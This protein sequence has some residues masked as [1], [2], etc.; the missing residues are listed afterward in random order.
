VL[1]AATGLAKPQSDRE[2][3]EETIERVL[4]G[5]R[6][7]IAIKGQPPVR[8]TLAEEM[9]QS[10]VP[11]ISIAVIDDGQIAWARGFGVKQAGTADPV[12]TSTL[13]EAQSI[14]KAVTAT[15]TLV[16]VNSGRLSLEES[17]NVYLKSW[18]LPYNEYQAQEKV[19]LRRILSH[20]SGLNVGSFAGYRAGEP[21]PSLLQI[22]DGEKPANN[23]PIRVDFTPGSKSRY[24]GGGAQV[25]EEL[26]M[27]VTSQP[28]PELMK[29]LVLVPAAMTLST[30]EEPLPEARWAEAASGH[31]GEGAVVKGKW[32]IQPQMAAGGLWT[33]PTDLA[34][35]ALQITRAWKG[36]R[37]RLFSKRIATEMLT[38]QKAPYGL[39]VEVQGTGSRLEFSHGGSNL[40]FRALMVMFPAVG[41]G[42]VMMA[43]GDRADWVI[44]SLIRSIASEYHW[45]ALMQTE[46]AVVPLGTAQLDALVG[47]YAL[48]PG[49]S[50][51][52]VTYEITR[53]GN[54]LFAELKGLGSYPKYELFPSNATSFFSL[55]GL[56]VNFTLDSS[57]RAS[58]LKMGEIMGIRK[59]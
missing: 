11:G 58:S 59:P 34:N 7:P 30:Y 1:L 48:P 41:K 10:H 51:E 46:R 19:T 5:M 17:P 29:R 35:W 33:T 36:G 57:G 56:D 39:G 3:S 31:D 21:L 4:S 52:P 6:P 13:F 25:M 40:G 26:L 42:A 50:G 27:D 47:V 22:L 55:V 38:V 37:N 23:P 53:N 54:K 15:A 12:T 14:S 49:P 28:F 18:K 32:L 24:S 8:S 20:S 2:A 43:N 44:G 9:A 16:L 45:P